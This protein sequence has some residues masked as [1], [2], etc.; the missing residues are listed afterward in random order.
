MDFKMLSYNVYI[1]KKLK[2]KFMF[3]FLKCRKRKMLEI[4]K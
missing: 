1:I 2:K 3:V 4:F